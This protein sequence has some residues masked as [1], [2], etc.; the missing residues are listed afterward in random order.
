MKN[1]N[2]NTNLHGPDDGPVPDDYGE[3]DTF[4]EELLRQGSVWQQSE[5][6]NMVSSF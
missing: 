5:L 1:G 3:G 4:S 6:G 2:Q